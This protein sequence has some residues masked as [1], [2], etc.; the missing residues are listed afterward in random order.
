MRKS[1]VLVLLLL[2]LTPFVSTE[3]SVANAQG[4]RLF[5]G[6]IKE[7]AEKAGPD[8]NGETQQEEL[9]P[10]FDVSRKD[11]EEEQIPLLPE[12]SSSEQTVP[13]GE[14]QG[15]DEPPVQRGVRA[16]VSEGGMLDFSSALTDDA[17]ELSGDADNI[18][19]T[20][21]ETNFAPAL[22]SYRNFP[23]QKNDARLNDVCFVSPT[24]GWAVGDRGVVWKTA[25]AGANWV[26]AE[27]P[28]DANLFGVSFL[29]ENYGLAVG[30]RVNPTSH[31]GQGVVLRTID[32]GLTWGEVPTAA[33]PILR[34]VK[35][36][37][38][39]YAWIAGD[40]S[41]LYPSGLFQ[42]RYR[43]RMDS[44]RWEQTRRLELRALRSDRTTASALRPKGV[45]ASTAPKPSE[46]P[47]RWERV[48]QEASSTTERHNSGVVVGDQGLTLVSSGLRRQLS[49]TPGRFPNESQNYFDLSASSRSTA[50]SGSWERRARYSSIRT[51]AE[52]FGTPSDEYQYSAR[53]AAFIDRNNGWAVGDLGVIVATNDGGRTWKPAFRRFARC[54]ARNIRA[55]RGRPIE[56]LVNLP[57]T[58]VSHGNSARRGA[59]RSK[60]GSPRNSIRRTVQRSARR[61]GRVRHDASEPSLC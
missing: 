28:T 59:K 27:T 18:P 53:K 4:W 13:Q 12:E 19:Q 60:K 3:P 24:Q 56:A 26:L 57:A 8:A 23:E 51:T 1:I 36:I 11:R 46:S 20:Y 6:K 32:G 48:A 54:Y 49:Q 25:D 44:R 42:H 34:D 37:D 9:P 58:A 33:F 10:L 5:S 2:V 45:Q 16:P 61:N 47:F 29:D 22:P 7:D 17:A 21:S 55:R 43:R 40:S 52:T 39:E 38:E 31:A 15:Y 50:L 30:G 14:T 41:D 35:I